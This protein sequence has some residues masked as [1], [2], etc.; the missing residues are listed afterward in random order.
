MA[1]LKQQYF[2]PLLLKICLGSNP[3]WK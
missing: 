2:M 3:E 1:I